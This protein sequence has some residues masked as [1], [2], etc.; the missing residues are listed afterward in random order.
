[1]AEVAEAGH[2]AVQGPLGGG[3]TRKRYHLVRVYSICEVV[4]VVVWA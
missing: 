3:P 4:V 1:M 2:F